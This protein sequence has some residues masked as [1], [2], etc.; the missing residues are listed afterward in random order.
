MSEKRPHWHHF[1]LIMR[2]NTLVLMGWKPN[3]D[4]S[5][6]PPSIVALTRRLSP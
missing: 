1:E 4:A 5:T 6:Q 3:L 2:G